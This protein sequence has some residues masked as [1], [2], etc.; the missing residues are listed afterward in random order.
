M[1]LFWRQGYAAT[2]VRDLGEALDLRPSSLYAAFGDKH[3]LFLRALDEY[4]RTESVTALRHLSTDGPV[5]SV[6]RAWLMDSVECLQTDPEAR[7]CFMVNTATEL[8]ASDPEAAARVRTAFDGIRAAVHD[9]LLR[10][11]RD[12]ELAPDLDVP[13]VSSLLTTTMIGLRAQGRG[14]ATHDDLTGA[15]EAALTAVR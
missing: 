8:G 2:S 1:H 9:L 7:G 6:I 13:G 5:R 10:G 14:G 4:A 11:R 15:V 3:R 12:G